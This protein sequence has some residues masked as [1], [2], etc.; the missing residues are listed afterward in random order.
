[1][2]RYRARI[3]PMTSV[4][5]TGLGDRLATAIT[6]AVGTVVELLER[7]PHAG[8]L[9]RERIGLP[10]T[11]DTPDGFAGALPHSLAETDRR[12][13]VMRDHRQGRELAFE[14]IAF[15]LEPGSDIVGIETH[16]PAPGWSPPVTSTSRS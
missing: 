7:P 13:R 12:R 16:S 5:A 11:F 3:E 9:R 8:Q 2:R 14:G 4:R 15:R 10:D 1:M 6:D